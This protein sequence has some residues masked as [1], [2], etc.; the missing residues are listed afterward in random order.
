ME[1]E[2][3]DE[4]DGEGEHDRENYG[5]PPSHPSNSVTGTFRA[6]ARLF[7]VLSGGFCPSTYPWSRKPCRT[8]SV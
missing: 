3:A 4:A 7:S 1:K 6:R 8:A 5:P 2:A